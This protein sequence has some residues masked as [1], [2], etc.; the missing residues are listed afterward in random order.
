MT[1]RG[2][3]SAAELE[4]LALF[5]AEA[6]TSLLAATFDRPIEDVYRKARALGLRKSDAF[7]RDPKR[8][9]CTDGTRGKETRFKPGHQSWNKGTKGLVLGGAATQFK[10]GHRPHTWVPVGSYRINGDGY[11]DCKLNDDPGPNTVRWKPVHR[12]VWEA[13]HGPVPPGHVVVF[14]PGRKTTDLALITL[15]AIELIARRE[16]MARNTVH[17]L[18]PELV[19]VV[20]LRGVLVRKINQRRTEDVSSK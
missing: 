17:N 4:V 14:K 9:Q 10:K 2:V 16:L 13:A 8:S 1:V 5:Y 3:W 12:L 20:R 15:D 19:S 7:R 6:P 11:L 18:P